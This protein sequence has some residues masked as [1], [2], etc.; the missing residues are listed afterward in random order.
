MKI[1]V[2]GAA[3]KT[4]RE[5]V[6]QALSQG[7]EVTAFIH[8]QG[9]G[10]TKKLNHIEGSVLNPDN[11]IS[12]MQSGFDV[13]ISALGNNNAGELACS[14]GINNII[15]AM[16]LTGVSRLI[17]ISSLGL[18]PEFNSFY[19]NKIVLPLFFNDIH[20]DLGKMEKSIQNSSL[21]WTIIRAPQLIEKVRTGNY[22]ILLQPEE[23]K[24]SQIGR[25]DVADFTLKEISNS[26]YIRQNVAIGY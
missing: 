5:I 25:G 7:H 20:K 8:N 17:C 12:A 23:E 9:L 19:F 24:L 1:L 11:V 16:Y 13:V 21:S 3:G 4:G 26:K 2:F 14:N 22:R 6:I 15:S 10:K 18:S